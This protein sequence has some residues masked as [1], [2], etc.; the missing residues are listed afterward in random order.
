[1]K[2]GWLYMSVPTKLQKGE[3][4]PS[5]NILG[6]K[7][8]IQRF[9]HHLS[10][11]SQAQHLCSTEGGGCQRG[12]ADHYG[13]CCGKVSHREHICQDVPPWH[14]CMVT[15]VSSVTLLLTISFLL[16]LTWS[17]VCCYVIGCTRLAIGTA[18]PEHYIFYSFPEA[19][20]NLP[21]STK[22]T[23]QL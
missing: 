23:P 3:G 4:L 21:W 11:R 7:V 8:N 22:E 15:E 13:H 2:C 10:Q 6:Q 5:K 12:M 20:G 14:W 1:M 18:P 17:F 16:S 19:S 9:L